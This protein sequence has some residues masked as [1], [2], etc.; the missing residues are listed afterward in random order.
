MK[1]IQ[2]MLAGTPSPARLAFNKKHVVFVMHQY[3]FVSQSLLERQ[4]CSLSLFYRSPRDSADASAHAH[5]RSVVP[6]DR[7]LLFFKAWAVLM[8]FLD[9]EGLLAPLRP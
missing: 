7:C 8:L 9:V 1:C 4:H 6:S 2:A 3:T 5:C